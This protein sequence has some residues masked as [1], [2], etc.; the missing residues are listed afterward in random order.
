MRASRVGSVTAIC[1]A[2]LVLGVGTP[3]LPAAPP[4]DP[5]GASKVLQGFEDPSTVKT[6]GGKIE[7]V[8]GGEGITEG[9]RAGRIA[10]S[11]A[12]EISL[13]GSECERFAWLQFDT[14]TVQPLPHRFRIRASGEDVRLRQYAYVQPGKDTLALPLSWLLVRRG[15][16]WP[17]KAVRLSIA[18]ASDRAVI[19][20]NIRLVPAAK[21]PQGGVLVDFGDDR[22]LVWPG[23]ERGGTENRHVVWSGGGSVYA[24]D[25]E[26]YPDPLGGDSVGPRL[27]TRS[28]DYFDLKAPGRGG[29]A[30]LWVTHFGY[31]RVQ[32]VEYALLFRGKKVLQ[33]RRSTKQMLGPEG[34]LEGRDGEWTPQWYDKVYAPRF[35]EV[36]KLQLRSAGNRIDVGNCQLAAVAMAP[37]ASRAALAEYVEQVNED[38]SRFR[39]QFIVGERNWPHCDLVPTAAERKA[40]VMLFSPPVDQAFGLEWRPQEKDRVKILRTTVPNGEMVTIPIVVV[41]LEEGTVISGAVGP[42]RADGGGVL[43][44]NRAR[45]G[46][47]C[48]EP[49]PR[50]VDARAESQP[51]I[52]VPKR[53]HVAD[54]EIVW[55]VLVLAPQ[56][57]SPS[58]VFKG[59][60]HFSVAGGQVSV[61]LE[62]RMADIGRKD[63]AWPTMGALYYSGDA[64]Y[65]YPAAAA[66]MSKSA[67]EAMTARLRGVLLSD[68]L[69]ALHLDA[70]AVT[71]DLEVVDRYLRQDL[72]RFPSDRAPGEV[73]FDLR[74]VRSRLGK[75]RV[76]RGTRK[77]NETLSAVATRTSKLAAEAGI[78]RFYF[79]A[80]GETSADRLRTLSKEVGSIG[81]AEGRL[82]VWFYLS[83]LAGMSEAEKRE[84]LRPFSAIIVAVNRPGFGRLVSLFQSLGGRRKAFVYTRRP[85]PCV[86]GFYAAVSGAAGSYVEEVYPGR[87]VYNGF[88]FD[89]SGIL[90]PRPDGSFAPTLGMLALRQ[91]VSDYSLVKRCEALLAE[92]AKAKLEA[93]GLAKALDDLK[94][95]MGKAPTTSYHYGPLRTMPMPRSEMESWRVVL[96]NA[97]EKVTGR[98]NKP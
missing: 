66:T 93:A 63:A 24:N 53:R 49:V 92:A 5:A 38:L 83:T 97:A 81:S 50:V 64:S 42:L 33:K 34:L 32:P 77:Y 72:K 68:A 94:A 44:V 95:R 86:V 13:L 43:V 37:G 71:S 12:I 19:L 98:L 51:W 26:G 57:D 22:Q 1:W 15:G 21:S 18:N 48:L 88:G 39:R 84:I 54:R 2:V 62:V 46:L 11:V 55:A 27:G 70:V 17:Q 90:V 7:T 67:K 16:Q 74:T 56:A 25:C 10:A 23:F 87:R 89:A 35:V 9:K 96:T 40:G 30:H 79:F 28:K 78:S 82:A 75:A 45:T 31:R 8:S 85:D 29:V 14:L 36:V 69:N 61:P 91:G 58:G 59:A 60:V 4:P 41:P 47:W 20:D 73:L 76:G 6:A 3:R 80:G 52:L 65:F